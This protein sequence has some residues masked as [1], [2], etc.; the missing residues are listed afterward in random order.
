MKEPEMTTHVGN[1]GT[2]HSVTQH[3]VT[4]LPAPTAW[5]F[6]LAAGI[7]LVLA[8]LVTNVGLAYL[9]A[10]LGVVS[11]VGWFRQ[12]LPHEKHEEI[13]VVT[14]PIKVATTRARVAR[15]QLGETHRAQLPLETYPVSSGILGGLAGGVAMIIPAE[16]Y[17]LLRF[18]SLWYTVNLLGGMGAFGKSNPSTAEIAQFH[19]T[20][21]LIAFIIHLATSLLVGLL[22][23]ALLPVWPRHP[24][25][26]G[27]IVGP[28]LWTGFLHSILGIVNPFF[29]ERISWPWFAASQVFFG[30]VAGWTV[31][32][33][34]RIKRLAQLPLSVRL[35]LQT[36]G[37]I[38]EKLRK[39]QPGTK[40]GGQ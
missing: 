14:Q 12:V 10:V 1:R 36:P 32:R 3:S 26:L 2:R 22:Y 20:A 29:N 34:G 27:G 15:I 31:T 18:H 8:S 33:R 30:L 37:V 25:L 24:I 7:A 5:P 11:A 35:G 13:P 40:G 4:E 19:L 6:M 16:I 39:E 21:F 38:G 17:G 28:V 23:G 9:G